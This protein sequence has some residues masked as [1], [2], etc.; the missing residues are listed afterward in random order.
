MSGGPVSLKKL[1]PSNVFLIHVFFVC[2]YLL[3][4][5]CFQSLFLTCV[6]DTFL[7]VVSS[8][9]IFQIQTINT[10]GSEVGSS[11][12]SCEPLDTW[13]VSKTGEPLDKPFET[14]PQQPNRN[15]H[16]SFLKK[17][18][19]KALKTLTLKRNIIE[20]FRPNKL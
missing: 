9:S 3:L 17:S 15:H 1:E 2:G 14:F 8:S 20:P 13:R 11:A 4:S 19:I 5:S 7:L 16:K 18:Y 6:F 10:S 12:L